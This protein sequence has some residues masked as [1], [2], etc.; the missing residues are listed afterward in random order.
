M[1]TKVTRANASKVITKSTFNGYD[2]CINPYV[3]CQFGC[4][5]C[6][7][8]FFVKDE[9]REWGDFVRT[10]DH[11]A[12]ALPRELARGS[13]RFTN[14]RQPRFDDNGQPML[15]SKGK[16]MTR[17]AYKT[18]PISQIRLVIG[19][20]TDPY[21]PQ[22]R[23][24]KLTNAALRIITDPNNPQF[25]KVGI[26]TR[27]PLVLHDLNLIQQL[28]KA[29][30]HFSI[31]PFPREVMKVIEPISPMPERRWDC[32]RQLKAAGIRTHVNVSP[33]MPGMSESMVDEWAHQLAEIGVDEYFVD[34]MQPYADS[35]DAFRKACQNSTAVDWPQIE[36]I[37]TNKQRYL[38][39]KNTF[40]CMWDEA[41]L[42]HKS[43]NPHQMPIWCD[44]ENHVWINM[45]TG[46]QM[47]RRCY[48]D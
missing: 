23:K 22:E 38:E 16:P 37:M 11:I 34:P 15:D 19:T 47:D 24:A 46:E 42:R 12:T 28:P 43:S 41:R 2:A 27:S 18:L 3:G 44:H 35:F 21:Q 45:N 31:T 39:W 1:T 13:A 8:R 25:K 17:P 36:E 33:V 26:F 5:Y 14:G 48:N 7:V 4:S 32:V 40:R 10:R 9:E 30:V 29:R 20:M 6:Y